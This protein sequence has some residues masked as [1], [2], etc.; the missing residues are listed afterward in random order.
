MKK[1]TYFLLLASLL[2]T[3]AIAMEQAQPMN[4]MPYPTMIYSKTNQCTGNLIGGKWVLTAQHCSTQTPATIQTAKQEEIDVIQQMNF[5]ESAFYQGVHADIALWELD[6]VA[7]MHTITP[8]TVTPV[9]TNDVLSGYGFD[10]T[11]Q[12]LAT[13]DVMV[14]DQPTSRSSKI[15]A[16]TLANEGQF[17]GGDSGSPYLDSHHHQVAVHQGILGNKTVSTSIS[18]TKD[19]ILDQIN[20]WHYPT[21]ID[22]ISGQY[23]IT[24]QSL[25]RDSV[26]D[27]AYAEGDIRIDRSQSTCAQGLIR[28]FDTCTYVIDSEGTEAKLHLSETETIMI[29]LPSASAHK[30]HPKH[31]NDQQGTAVSTTT[32]PTKHGGTW[33]MMLLV[34]LATFAFFSRRTRQ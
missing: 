11:K 28:P 27:Q 23:T 1:N 14:T 18:T 30:P 9:H 21:K 15:K 33:N 8:L 4:K 7:N 19:F 24:I 2:A 12:H 22:A 3:K 32:S 6:H 34:I 16:I 5:D 13:I 20:G 25:H 10:S 29:N 17:V 31:I 26:V